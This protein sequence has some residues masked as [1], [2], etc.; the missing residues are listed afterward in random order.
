[1]IETG[2]GACTVYPD[3]VTVNC[4]SQP[5]LNQ[6][7]SCPTPC[8]ANKCG[9]NSYCDC[10]TGNCIC[11]SGF[12]G[13]DC[14]TDT[15][16]AAQCDPVN[17]RCSTRYLGGTLAVTNGECVCRPGTYGE[18]C[19][20]NPC[21]GNTCSGHGSC[22][23]MGEF[24]YTCICNV[25]YD[26]LKCENQCTPPT[27]ITDKT[28]PNSV[29]QP[30]CYSGIQYYPDVDFHGTDTANQPASTAQECGSYCL[31]NPK[32]NAFVFPGW[33]YMKTGVSSYTSLNT[34]VG[35]ARC[36]L[37]NVSIYYVPDNTPTSS[38]VTIPT[39]HSTIGHLDVHPS[40]SS[41]SSMFIFFFAFLFVFLFAWRMIQK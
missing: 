21:A 40:T 33:C 5:V 34:T 31:A 25:G 3:E 39:T 8:P 22:K 10:G 36:G 11:N 32:C 16:A 17:G 19:D 38:L 23:I 7:E 1:M 20:A 13:P 15:C 35:G 28:P 26:G 6:I 27:N 4:K 37:V 2:R 14:K 18:K 12:Y 29:C 24:D 9:P 41:N 30:P